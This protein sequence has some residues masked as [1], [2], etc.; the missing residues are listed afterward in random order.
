VASLKAAVAGMSGA[1]QGRPAMSPAL[2]A[3]DDAAPA[4]GEDPQMTM[5]KTMVAR[6]AARMEQNQGDA[7]GW[8]KLAHAYVVLGQKD[9]ARKAIDHAVKLKPDDAAVLE[10]LAET[11]QMASPHD[12]T[13]PDFIATL[14]K[15][16]KRDPDNLQA[17]YY[18]GLSQQTAGHHDAA[19]ALWTKALKGPHDANDPLMIAIRNRMGNAKAP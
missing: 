6:L 1:M 2:A 13:P 4:A 16:L 17:L 9:D 11:Q 8:R 5:I 10:T 14:G 3:S 18:I 19:I 12:E 7:D 15:V